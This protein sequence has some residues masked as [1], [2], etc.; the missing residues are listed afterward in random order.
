MKDIPL[1]Q[2]AGGLASLTLSQIPLQGAGWARIHS[3]DPARLSELLSECRTVFRLCRAAEAFVSAGAEPLPGLE[4]V[5]ET[6]T[7][8][9]EKAPQTGP[10]PLALL[11][12]SPLT[13]DTY[14]SVYNRAFAGTRHNR[15]Y[16][17]ADAAA[18]VG[19]AYLA[20]LAGVPVGAGEAVP[21]ELRAVGLLPE[22]RGRGLSRALAGQLLA[23]AGDGPVLV[24]T[25]GD[26][27]PAL[28]LYRSLGFA[29][30]GDREL[31]YRLY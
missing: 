28:A 20:L 9:C 1:F 5:Y 24:Q 26:N 30:T 11:P 18:A 25:T 13:A 12:V 6:L 31:W 8:E 29:P 21:G 2:A 7:L 19:Q 16:R 14:L 15:I 22:F 4:A 27:R 3:Y 10:G 17:P 23:R